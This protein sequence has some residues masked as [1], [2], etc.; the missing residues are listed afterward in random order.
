MRKTKFLTKDEFGYMQKG[1]LSHIVQVAKNYTEWAS[2][3]WQGLIDYGSKIVALLDC[4]QRDRYK[5]REF[6][7]KILRAA[8]TTSRIAS[9][10]EEFVRKL[11]AELEKPI[12]E[13]E[14]TKEVFE[15][16][17]TFHI[18]QRLTEKNSLWERNVFY[19]SKKVA[20]MFIEKDRFKYRL[21]R[22]A[23]TTSQI[24]SRNEEFV[25]QLREKLEKE[26]TEKGETL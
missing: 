26:A 12:N 14:I 7:Y 6:R 23:Y 8:Y 2:L 24:A 21:L 10:N 19:G 3:E 4:T 13:G 20:V 18:T 15:K 5:P 1:E 16:T 17:V 22:A 9:R 25:R 11:K